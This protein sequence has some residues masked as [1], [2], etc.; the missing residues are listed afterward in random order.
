MNILHIL[1]ADNIENDYRLIKECKTLIDASAKP[2]ILYFHVNNKPQSE[3]ELKAGVKWKRKKLF[4]REITKS[5]SLIFFKLLEQWA[6]SA[7]F[8]LFNRPSVVCIHDE[9]FFGLIPFCSA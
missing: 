1:Q 3:G 4:I 8:I 2:E 7:I 9:R 5:G 6:R